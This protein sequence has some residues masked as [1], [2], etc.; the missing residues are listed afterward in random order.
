[1]DRDARKRR[2]RGREPA[3][4]PGAEILQ[5][6][7]AELGDLVEKLMVERAARLGERTLEEPEVHQHARR[8][9][10]LAA[11]RHLG[12]IRVAMDTPA[13]LGLDRALQRMRSVEAELLGELEHQGIPMN[14]WVCR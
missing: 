6:R 8:L 12:A 9:V 11:D 2:H 3:P 14:L 7:W 4:D 1:M 13:R 5:R 10:G